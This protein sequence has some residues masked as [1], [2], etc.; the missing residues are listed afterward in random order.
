MIKDNHGVKGVLNLPFL[1]NSGTYK[2]KSIFQINCVNAWGNSFR[3]F[4]D[5]KSI[6]YIQ[7]HVF[8]NL[9]QINLV[10]EGPYIFSTKGLFG[11]DWAVRKGLES[12]DKDGQ[13]IHFHQMDEE[14][15]ETLMVCGL[16]LAEKIRRDFLFFVPAIL[17]LWTVFFLLV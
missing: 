5:G 8:R 1:E 7:M 11:I 2:G 9:A 14:L 3:I 16:Y 10:E 6:G 17:I 4:R 13:K 12:V 15:Q